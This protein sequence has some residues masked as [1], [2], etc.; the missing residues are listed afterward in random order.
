MQKAAP[1][2]TTQGAAAQRLAKGLGSRQ[3]LAAM[4][5]MRL[6]G[7]CKIYNLT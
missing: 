1:W 2:G 4:S 5:A 3:G 6:D 7:N